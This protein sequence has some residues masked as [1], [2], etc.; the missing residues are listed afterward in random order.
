MKSLQETQTGEAG[1]ENLLGTGTETSK[2]SLI[3]ITQEME[4]RI[5]NIED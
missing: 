5:P 3:N 1:N 4:E 2:A